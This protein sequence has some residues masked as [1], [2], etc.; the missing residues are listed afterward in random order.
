MGKYSIIRATTTLD[1]V[2]YIPSQLDTKE[3]L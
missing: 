2:G 3:Y 1:V